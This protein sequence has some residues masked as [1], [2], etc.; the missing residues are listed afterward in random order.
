MTK[1]F[2]PNRK[3]ITIKYQ[4]FMRP[5]RKQTMYRTFIKKSQGFL[6]DRKLRLAS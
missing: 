2:K 6:Y 5:I 4:V 3:R 1:N